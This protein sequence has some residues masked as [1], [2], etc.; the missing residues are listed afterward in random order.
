MGGLQRFV[1]CGKDSLE[2]L[3]DVVIPKTQYSKSLSLEVVI[4]FGIMPR[5]EIEVMLTT[6]DFNNEIMSQ[7]H[8]IDDIA[9]QWGLTAEMKASLSPFA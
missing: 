7:T 2:I 9:L 1:Y 5:M 3:I 8:E 6:I 4:A